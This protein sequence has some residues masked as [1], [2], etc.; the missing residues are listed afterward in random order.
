MYRGGIRGRGLCLNVV[1]WLPGMRIG[2]F[3]AG[4][5][6]GM[7]VFPGAGVYEVSMFTLLEQGFLWTPES[8]VYRSPL[9]GPPQKNPG[10]GLPWVIVSPYFENFDA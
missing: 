5:A 1:N 3:A 9:P 8:D 7:L 2:A 4:P 10:S 6:A